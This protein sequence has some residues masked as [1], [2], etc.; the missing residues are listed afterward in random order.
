MTNGGSSSLSTPATLYNQA[1][2]TLSALP[3]SYPFSTKPGDLAGMSRS[4][5]LWR[6]LNPAGWPFVRIV[7]PTASI[8]VLP[9]SGHSVSPLDVLHL[10]GPVRRRLPRLKPFFYLFKVVVL[11]QALTA[12]SLWALLAYLLK[13]A[14]LLDAQRNRGGRGDKSTSKETS[15]RP[16]SVSSTV[17]PRLRVDMLPCGH[18]SDIESIA[19]SRSGCVAVSVSIDDS[20]NL[21]RFDQRP[22]NGTR[23]ILRTPSPITNIVACAVSPDEDYV[24]VATADGLVQMWRLLDDGPAKPLEPLEIHFEEETQVVRVELEIERQNT[25]ID[26]FQPDA[27]DAAKG[28]ETSHDRAP[29]ALILCSEGSL[30]SIDHHRGQ[31]QVISSAEKGSHS[32]FISSNFGLSPAVVTIGTYE[33]TL[34]RATDNWEPISLQSHRSPGDLCTTVSPL[35]SLPGYRGNQLL[36]VGRSSG[37]I[38]VFDATGSLVAAVG[39]AQDMARIEQVDIAS[40][41]SSRCTGC[42]ATCDEGFYVISTSGEHKVYIDKIIPPHTLVCR[43]APP[44]RSFDEAARMSIAMGSPSKSAESLVVPPSAA[45]AKISPS[46]SPRRSPSLL[47]PTSNGEFPLSSHGTRKLSAYQSHDSLMATPTANGSLG[48]SINEPIGDP[49]TT[50]NG[51]MPSPDWSDMEVFPL[52]AVSAPDGN[53]IVVDDTVLGLRRS[54]PGIGHEQWQ[55]WAIDLATPYNG[56]TLNVETVPLIEL[57]E[58]TRDALFAS[59]QYEDER[60]S[61]SAERTERLLSLSGRATFPPIRGSLSVPTYPNLAYIEIGNLQPKG[62]RGCIA[63]FGN[64]VGVFTLNEREKVEYGGGKYGLGAMTTPRSRLNS[65]SAGG[66]DGKRPPVTLGLTPPPPRKVS[67]DRKAK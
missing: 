17:A 54:S 63:G 24:A 45:R 25:T 20:I 56:S 30:I 27:R 9:T 66:V 57:E 23:E 55:V 12:G 59:L 35:R 8:I 58:R 1:K 6:S 37:L 7:I 13:D 42:N 61:S 49:G 2:Q 60:Y 4:E 40:P 51:Q 38:E 28:S 53:W 47:P 52:G 29:T 50:L 46:T 15:T 16:G 44:R 5:G 64:Q 11:P 39:Q 19:A 65:T 34:Y 43:C 21:W 32:A 33:E 26:P 62:N 3:R 48:L 10:A 67:E 31:R 36:A 18:A 41:E 22:G 14:E